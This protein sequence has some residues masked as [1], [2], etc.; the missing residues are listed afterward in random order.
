MLTL[1]KADH[2]ELGGYN[3]LCDICGF[4]FKA[5]QLRKRWDNLMVCTSDYEQRH[6]QDLIRLR[7]ERQSVPWAR[8]VPTPQFVTVAPVD[9]STL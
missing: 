1:G 5:S 4:K 7:P 8:P 6:P 9:P 3:A 2:L